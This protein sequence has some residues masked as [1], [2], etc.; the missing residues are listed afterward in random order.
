RI[1][2]G[3][4]TA[5]ANAASRPT[6]TRSK[7]RLRAFHEEGAIQKT[8]DFVLL[9]R[10]IPFVKPHAGS[11]VLSLVT[12]LVLCGLR[13]GIPLLMGR[14]VAHAGAGDPRSILKTGTEL[15]ALI[16]VVQLL[17]FA[18]V[19]SMQIVGARARADL[20][21]HVFRFLQRLELRYYDRTPVGRLVT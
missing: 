6:M 1:G 13:L 12:L 16:V 18:Q 7:E 15:A 11:L 5:N 4:T 8:Y 9:R 2:G 3:M 20:R 14:V 17:T 19:Y 10:L 21:V